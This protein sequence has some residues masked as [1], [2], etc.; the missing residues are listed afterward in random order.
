MSMLLLF[1]QFVDDAISCQILPG[2]EFGLSTL[3]VANKVWVVVEGS[4]PLVVGSATNTTVSP[5]YAESPRET[6]ILIK[7]GDAAL[8]NA[9]AA[10]QLALLQVPRKKLTGISVPLRQGLGIERGQ[11]VSIL[12]PRVGILGTAFAVRRIE[13]DFGGDVTLLDIGEYLTPRDDE[14]GLAVIAKAL[15]Q[16]QKESA[17]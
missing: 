9:V 10:A 4:S 12:V 8:C 5:T 13:H 14:A 3:E 15:A 17:I 16:L 11:V 6:V 1:N 7:S 2:V